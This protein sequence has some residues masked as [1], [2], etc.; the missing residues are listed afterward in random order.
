[1]LDRLGF[2]LRLRLRGRPAIF[3][4]SLM[5]VLLLSLLFFFLVGN[6]MTSRVL[7]FPGLGAHRVVAEERLIPRH[8]SFEENVTAA[9]EEV[10]LGPARNDALRLFPRGA[11]VISTF[12]TGRTLV[13]DLSPLVLLDDAEVPLKGA[14]ALDTLARSLRFNFPRIREVD[15]Y[16]DGQAP[17]FLESRKI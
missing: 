15:F 4:A 7:F 3:G 10:L 2:L 8:R 5:G 17:R 9:A 16:I 14:A 11:R 1:V 6:G 12:V 13:M